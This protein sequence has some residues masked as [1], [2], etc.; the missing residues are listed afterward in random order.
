MGGGV[1][2]GG[3]AGAECESHDGGAGGIVASRVARAFQ[4]GG[5]S[6]TVSSEETSGLSALEVAVGALRRGEIGVALVGAVDL[7]GDLRAVM[8]RETAG[9]LIGEGAVAVVLKREEDA[10]RD[11]DR[12][13]AVI[14]W[15]DAKAAGGGRF[16]GGGVWEM[17]TAGAATGFWAVVKAARIVF[18]SSDAE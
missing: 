3:G 18:A 9:G 4:V 6:F 15:V 2:A 8:A 14:G 5:P 12:I 7:A 1:E 11:G 16:L 13:Y 10:L 17:G